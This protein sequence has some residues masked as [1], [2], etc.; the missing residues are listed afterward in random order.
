MKPQ[1]GERV[2]IEGVRPIIE[3]IRA[4]RRKVH[5]VGLPDEQSTPG[6]RDLA[7][8][9]TEAGISTESTTGPPWADA[10]PYREEAAEELLVHTDA[11]FLVALDRLTDVGNLGSIL[12]SAEIAGV[13][14]IALEHRRSPPIA[15][16][17]L[18]AS[19]GAVEHLRLGRT[20]N[21]RKFLEIASAEGLR[22]LVADGSGESIDSVD[23][24]CFRGDIAWVFGSED[25]GVKQGIREMADRCIAIPQSGR[26]G[27]LGVAAA[28][29]HLLLRT[30]EH[31]RAKQPLN[32]S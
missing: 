19:A 4:R 23:S 28:A 15:A 13:T 5:H 29:A 22:I 1:T 25:R 8:R 14:G 10:D 20:P 12:R 26:I 32:P 27:S 21:L 30:A 17:V 16:G 11:R 9:V 3:A 18:R 31:R 7:E 24:G 6:L 2:R